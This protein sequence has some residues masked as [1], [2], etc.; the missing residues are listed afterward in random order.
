MSIDCFIPSV[1][2]GYF[3]DLWMATEKI[4][5][6]EKAS[7]PPS[8]DIPAPLNYIWSDNRRIKFSV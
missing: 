4:I 3:I 2:D 6:D 1:L 7:V 5:K 8:N